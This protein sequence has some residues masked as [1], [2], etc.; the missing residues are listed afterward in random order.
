MKTF[1]DMKILIFFLILVVTSTCTSIDKKEKIPI[2]YLTDLYH[3]HQ[4]PD[5]HFDLAA[6]FAI[7]D[8]DIKAVIVDN[9]MADKKPA[10]QAVEQMNHISGRKV[11]WFSGLKRKLKFPEDDGL[12][13]KEFQEGC[14][15]IIKILEETHGKVTIISVGSLRDIAAAYNR[16]PGLFHEKLPKIV[17]FA[18]EASDRNFI[19]YN[20]GLDKNAFIRVMNNVPNIYWVPCFDGG[21]WHNNGK[22]S[23]WQASQ[24]D[25]LRGSDPRLINYFLYMFKNEP[26]SV[27]PV[28]YIVGPSNEKAVNKY[29][30]GKDLSLR[31]LWSCAVFPWFSNDYSSGSYP[32]GFEQVRIQVNDS[33]I[34]NYLTNGHAVQRF[35][36]TDPDH[37]AERMT[38]IFREM[39]TRNS[40]K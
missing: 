4:D 9:A 16:R 37:Y 18:G 10:W 35:Y 7:D 13:Q 39:I 38:T 32:F 34:V 11:P 27:D 31:N 6:L 22:A 15:Q 36:I 28:Q 24:S 12:W 14:D 40:W 21:L 3:P 2:I 30:M 19:E 26:D 29:I 33:A 17:V 5:D 25:L 23:Y 8:F 20:V 1:S